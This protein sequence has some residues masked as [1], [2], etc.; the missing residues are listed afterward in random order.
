MRITGRRLIAV[1]MAAGAVWLLVSSMMAAAA[2]IRSR[3]AIESSCDSIPAAAKN[4]T[5][6]RLKG[7]GVNFIHDSFLTD[8]TGRRIRRLVPLWHID[9]EARKAIRPSNYV[10]TV[11]LAPTPVVMAVGVRGQPDGFRVAPAGGL[12]LDGL[13]ML[14]ETTGVIIGRVGTS[15]YRI[16]EV[17]GQESGVAE[18][19]VIIDLRLPPDMRSA[20]WGSAIGLALLLFAGFLFTRDSSGE[21]EGAGA[22]PAGAL[23]GRS[24]LPPRRAPASPVNEVKWGRVFV[25]V[26][27]GV[28]ALWRGVTWYFD[29]LRELRAREAARVGAAAVV[30]SPSNP[31]PIA[32]PA[33]TPEMPEATDRKSVV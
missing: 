8:V 7:C 33:P 29:P 2:G 10:R 12:Y 13:T 24:P 17:T 27:V 1:V 11:P 15:A 26:L 5:W 32:T 14:V 20:G 6:V 3:R 19:A 31:G 23:P 21:R 22:A 30:P 28:V 16:E 9:A 25:F 4:G 18:G